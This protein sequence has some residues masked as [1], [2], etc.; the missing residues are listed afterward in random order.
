MKG[1]GRKMK[2]MISHED[3]SSICL[4][5]SL[6][7]HAGIGVGDALALLLEESSQEYEELLTGIAKEVD[8]GAALSAALRNTGRFPVYVAGLVEVGEQAGRT[9][10]ALRALS[11]Y[12]E[13]RT[14]LDRRVRSALLYPAVMLMLMLVVIAVLLI[15]VLPIFEDVYRSLGGRLTGM[16]GGLL[17]LGRLLDRI[18]P[19][20][21]VLLAAFVLFFGV[22]AVSG[23]FREKILSWWRKLWG[24][25]GIAGRMNT[26]RLAQA[27]S[28]GMSSGL[29]LEEAVALAAGLVEDVPDAKKRCMDCRDR[30][31]KGEN[32][33]NA[34]KESGLLPAASCRLLELGQR[35]G[36]G[37]VSME[38]I[39]RDMAEESEASL[40]EMVGRVEPALVLVCSMLVG[41]IL[42]SV[43]LPLMHIMSTI[44]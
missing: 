20:L 29:S 5:L 3:I 34:L 30:L 12:Y 15:K 19:V 2:K 24:D 37:D 41:L 33:G 14:R 21:W 1:M 35:S 23:A 40:E 28:M 25:K 13:Y 8:E 9:E 7:L 27:L 42:L 17:S 44:G 31:E 26:A 16:A 4:E 38:K 18:M 43:M 39:A 10:E 22:F 36:S 32:Q 6:L 11:G